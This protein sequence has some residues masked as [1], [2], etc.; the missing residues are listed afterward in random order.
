MRTLAILIMLTMPSYAGNKSACAKLKQ[1]ITVYDIS[2][3]IQDDD[4]KKWNAIIRSS[5]K[6]CR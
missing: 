2:A 1:A 3:S 5:R 6:V 4:V